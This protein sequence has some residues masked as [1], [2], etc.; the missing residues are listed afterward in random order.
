MGCLQYQF[1]KHRR[2][3]FDLMALEAGDGRSCVVIE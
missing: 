3:V 2:S 1:F